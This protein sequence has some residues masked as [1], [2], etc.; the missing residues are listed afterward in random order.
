M[1]GFQPPVK[2]CPNRWYWGVPLAA[3]TG[4]LAVI[5]LRDNRSLFLEINRLGGYL[6]DSIWAHITILGDTLTVLTLC[7]P[8]ARR[9]P[10]PVWAGLLGGFPA[11]ALV[12]GLK[13]GLYLPRPAAV[14]PPDQLHLIGHP[15]RAL[16]FPSGHTATAFVLA[17]VLVFHLSAAGRRRWAGALLVTAAL[18]GLSRVAVGAHWPLDVLGGVVVGWLAAVLGTFWGQRWCWGM[19]PAVRCGLTLLLSGCALTALLHYQTGYPQTDG[20]RRLLALLC[21]LG[22]VYPLRGKR[23]KLLP[24]S[25]ESSPKLTGDS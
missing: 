2:G 17:G 1:T 21:L 3:L 20:A 19:T 16:S 12:Q 15:L 9:W 22:A 13:H 23:H 10:E 8:L 14:L 25:V 18:V 5:L 6:G 11:A 7:L 4:M 24:S